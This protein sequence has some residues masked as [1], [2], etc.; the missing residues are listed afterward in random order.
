MYNEEIKKEF[1]EGIG[2][3][4]NYLVL[5]NQTKELEEKEHDD[6]YNIPT[7]V[8]LK[9]LIKKKTLTALTTAKSKYKVIKRYKKWAITKDLVEQG[10]K[11][12]EPKIDIEQLY[13][14]YCQAVIF[15]T[16]KQLIDKLNECLYRRNNEG[17]SSD[18][19]IITY[20]I[21]LYQGFQTDEI[22]QLKLSNVQLVNNTAVIQ[23]D[24][25]VVNVY[26]EFIE[27][28]T[29]LYYC[30]TYS[31]D[32]NSDNSTINMNEYYISMGDQRTQ[33]QTKDR[34]TRLISKRVFPVVK[35]NIN[36]LYIMG[37]MYEAKLFDKTFDEF[38]DKFQSEIDHK[39]TYKDKLRLMYE[40]W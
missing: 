38:Y 25:K 37:R 7:D 30:R 40:T 17:I 26:S 33:K 28:L 24:R 20:L 19:L 18:E 31:K 16:P 21:L 27:S 9:Y 3:K 39:I 2:N 10:V 13:M 8:T 36:D 34:I 5:F 29:R 12:I 6:L 32:S 22:F 1:L 35:F 4:T 23:N 15:K 14:K 11:Y